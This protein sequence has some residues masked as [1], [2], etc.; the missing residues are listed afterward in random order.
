MIWKIVMV[1]GIL[2][3]LLGLA[4][5]GISVALPLIS[6]HTSWGEAM[7]GIIPGVLVLVISF[8]IFVLGLIFVIKNRK[9]A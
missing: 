9:K 2:G 3:V 1:V 6:S 5:T 4:V 7:I 8:F